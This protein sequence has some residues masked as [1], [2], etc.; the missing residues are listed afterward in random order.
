MSR[1]IPN[2]FKLL[3]EAD[4]NTDGII[5]HEGGIIMSIGKR[6]RDLRKELELTQNQFGAKL[7]I[8]GR[9]LARYE[10]GI[11]TPSIDILMKIADFCE[12]SL[13]YLAYGHDKQ[14][15]RR[16]KINDLEI[17]DLLRRM[18]RLKKTMRNRLKWAMGGLLSKQQQ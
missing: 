1:G 8:H 6:I 16:A 15:A 2:N 11:N 3:K 12:V 9:Q 17:L 7:G 10:E 4:F 5:F 14:I 13:D 18:D